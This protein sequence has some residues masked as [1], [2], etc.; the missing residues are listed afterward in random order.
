MRAYR[1]TLFFYCAFTW[2]LLLSGAT[3]YAQEG[4]VAPSVW[5]R[6]EYENDSIV[7]MVSKHENGD[8][9]I[10]ESVIDGYMNYNP[11]IPYLNGESGVIV[12]YRMRSNS[13]LNIFVV[14]EP[15]GSGSPQTLWAIVPDSLENIHFTT[16]TL[17]KRSGRLITFADT[18]LP[19]AVI[20]LYMD[21]WN[22][23][24]IS[25]GSHVKLFG[26]D[27]TMYCGKFSE[28]M[29]FDKQIDAL[30]IC[31]VYSYLVMKHSITVQ[32]LDL[33]NSTND[34]IWRYEENTEYPYEM[35]VLCRDDGYGLHQKQ[36][37]ANCASSELTVYVG[38][39][40]ENNRNNEVVLEDGNYLVI[41]SNGD[42]INSTSDTIYSGIGSEFYVCP[43]KE[44]KASVIGHDFHILPVNMKQY[45]GDQ[46]DSL[47]P[48]L[49]ILR[50]DSLSYAT[51]EME[52]YAPDSVDADGYY[53]YNN[54]I[55][56]TDGDGS[57]RFCFAKV[58]VDELREKTTTQEYAEADNYN[59]GDNVPAQEGGAAGNGKGSIPSDN[60]YVDPSIMGLNV[61]PNPSYGDFVVAVD[62]AGAQKI[63]IRIVG[64]DGKTISST[65]VEGQNHYELRERIEQPGAYI[66]E[67]STVA[68]KQAISVVV[69]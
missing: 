29:F 13:D 17:R 10:L 31:K 16:Q 9:V 45:Y 23:L 40:C 15:V 12:P 3:I 55:W 26:D 43:R 61:F 28:F 44:W 34:T 4:F 57:D 39:L 41:T 38:S 24:E 5:V 67:V 59:A 65:S 62:L 33:I 2:A 47:M 8:S 56:D 66:I 51:G 36:C 30:D 50:A 53:Y 18:T 46:P 52:V 6:A 27:S 68:D 60:A 14:Y 37:G 19:S 64:V 1:K 49:L 25:D 11:C 48:R 35:A 54:I 22:G 7:K 42:S 63:D 58:F 20:N 69:Y 32:G 21:R